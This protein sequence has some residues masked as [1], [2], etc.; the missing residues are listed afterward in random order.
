MKIKLTKQGE[1]NVEAFILECEAKRKEILDAGLDT[2]NDTTIPTVSDIISDMEFDGIDEEGEYINCWGV[3]DNTDSSPIRLIVG[4]DFIPYIAPDKWGVRVDW[5]CRPSE[6]VKIQRADEISEETPWKTYLISKAK[7]A[8]N[9]AFLKNCQPIDQEWKDGLLNFEWSVYYKDK[10]Y[11]KTEYPDTLY[12]LRKILLDFAGED[13]CLC[14]GPAGVEDCKRLLKDGQFWLG[15]SAKMMKGET[16]Q[17]HANSAEL[18]DINKNNFDVRICTGYALSDDGMWREHSWL[19][20]HHE[21]SNEII[22]TTVKRV[23]YFGWVLTPEECTTAVE[24]WTW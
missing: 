16:S 1:K 8:A 21:R 4:E 9:R 5:D 13:T 12:Q 11:L 15:R 14:M 6:L 2:A 10:E 17:C 23:C 24:D 19:I 7:D 18:Y 3:G 20:R 22:E